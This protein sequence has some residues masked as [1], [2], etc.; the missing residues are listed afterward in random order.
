M[1][2]LELLL[3]NNPVAPPLGGS[4]SGAS[5]GGEVLRYRHKQTIYKEGEPADTLFYIHEGAVRLTTR[6]N[7]QKS[8][9]TTILGVDEFFGEV[10]LIGYPLRVSTAVALGD[11]SIRVIKKTKMLQMLR[12]KNNDT[13]NSFL[14]HLL[15]SINSYKGHMA[16]LLTAYAEQRLALVLLRMAHLDKDGPAVV[17]IPVV[18]HQVLAEMVGTTR[19]RVNLFM[20]QFRKRGFITYGRRLVIHKSLLVVLQQ[21]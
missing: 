1:S 9:V 8:P 15:S 12:K 4:F 19:P 17:E 18:S 3:N 5:L 21:A 7:Y 16:A 6:T 13:S 11:S 10:C 14:G 2:G 20:N